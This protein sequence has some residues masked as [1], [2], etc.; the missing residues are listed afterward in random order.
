M[1]VIHSK[2]DFIFCRKHARSSPFR[3][4]FAPSLVGEERSCR[5]LQRPYLPWRS[6]CGGYYHC[7]PSKIHTHFTPCKEVQ[8]E[9]T[10]LC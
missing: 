6:S 4:A 8:Q 2:T 7:F 5:R 10:T 1:A 3:D 9:V